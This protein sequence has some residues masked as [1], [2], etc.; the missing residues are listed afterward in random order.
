MNSVETK[1][2]KK[3]MLYNPLSGGSEAATPEKLTDGREGAVAVNMLE[4]GDYKDFFDGIS[5]EDDI[6]LCGGDGTLNRFVNDTRDIPIRNDIFYFATGSGNDFAHDLGY[7]AYR[8]PDFCIDEYVSN[9]PRVIVGGREMLYVNNVGF[10][11][12]GYCCEVG[13]DMRE[14]NKTAKKKKAINYTAI[15]IKGLLFHFKPRN[16]VITVDGKTYEYKK[17]WLAP[18]MNGRFYGGG[19]MATPNQNRLDKDGKQSVLVFHG[20]GRLKTL[21]IFPSI[22]KGEHVKNTKHVTVLE[23][24]DIKVEFD[25]PTTVQVDG[26]TIRG[27]TSYEVKAT[28]KE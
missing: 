9:L 17:V 12:D 2:A 18:T 23:G 6:V 28:A 14:A 1:R 24:Y 4:I 15:A 7:S 3:Y 11:I 19:M 20:S 13:D 26:E 16:A 21:M 25:A 8:E 5:D 22:F 27:I 10:G